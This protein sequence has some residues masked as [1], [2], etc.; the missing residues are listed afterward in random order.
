MSESEYFAR[1][2]LE[3]ATDPRKI[4]IRSSQISR[5]AR[6]RV[7]AGLCKP[8]LAAGQEAVP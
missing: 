1:R 7:A 3:S 4:I 6:A 2:A 8:P 5:P